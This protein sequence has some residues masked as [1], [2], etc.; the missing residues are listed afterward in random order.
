[1]HGCAAFG[2]ASAH[3]QVNW[4]ANK[5]M[6]NAAERTLS[7]MIHIFAYHKYI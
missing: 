6:L 4:L 5:Q 7:E 2:A 1:M 3:F